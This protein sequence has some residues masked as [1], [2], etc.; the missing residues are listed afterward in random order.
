MRF[1]RMHASTAIITWV[2]RTHLIAAAT[3]LWPLFS[4][5]LL[6]SELHISPLVMYNLHFC[7]Y[8]LPLQLSPL[9]SFSVKYLL[10]FHLFLL[11]YLVLTLVLVWVVFL[12]CFFTLLLGDTCSL[13]NWL[14][15]HVMHSLAIFIVCS[16]E[17]FVYVN[18]WIQSN[19]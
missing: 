11:Y 9:A 10:L 19:H 8:S 17:S 3:P 14:M 1:P 6:H 2:Y 5:I 15:T 13:I 12:F 7:F 16:C 18:I 4:I